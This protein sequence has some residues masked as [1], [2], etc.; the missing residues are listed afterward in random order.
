MFKVANES[1]T[2][3][4]SGMFVNMEPDSLR[5]SPQLIQ[6]LQGFDKVHLCRH[7]QCNEDGQHFKVY[8]LAQ[9]VDPEKFHLHQAA[10]EAKS[11]GAWLWS[12]VWGGTRKVATRVRDYASESECDAEPCLA[13]RVGWSTEKGEERLSRSVCTGTAAE[14]TILL[15]EDQLGEQDSVPLCSSHRATYSLQRWAKKCGNLECR[16]LGLCTTSGYPVLGP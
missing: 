9:R 12:F 3:R 5:G 10:E 15:R 6:A 4:S 13:H 11:W 1:Q 8:G 2:I 14:R 7:D 16:R